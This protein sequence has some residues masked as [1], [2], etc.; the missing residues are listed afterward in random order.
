MEVGRDLEGG[1]A[2]HGG[3]DL[4]G[5]F[6]VLLVHLLHLLVLGLLSALL[7]LFLTLL[8]LGVALGEGR[9]LALLSLVDAGHH[10]QHVLCWHKVVD[11]FTH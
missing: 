9:D 4:V 5:S 1:T 2:H 6:F 11:R 7:D 3:F 10:L 8:V